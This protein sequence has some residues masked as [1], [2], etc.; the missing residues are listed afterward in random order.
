MLASSW[1]SLS[2]R[3]CVCRYESARSKFFYVGLGWYTATALFAV[4]HSVG[5][6]VA[7]AVLSLTEDGAFCPVARLG[8]FTSSKLSRNLLEDL[9]AFATPVHL[10]ASISRF[11]RP[12]RCN[13][14]RV[15]VDRVTRN[16]EESRALRLTPKELALKALLDYEYP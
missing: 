5:G 7:P 8:S 6:L 14:L 11:S 10:W 15:L 4:R 1:P 2:Y 12:S 16:R 9:T 3:S 13:A